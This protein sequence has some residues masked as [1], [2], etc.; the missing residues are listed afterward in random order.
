M[1]LLLSGR[2]EPRSQSH[3]APK[4]CTLHIAGFLMIAGT[5]IHSGDRLGPKPGDHFLRHDNRVANAP[6]FSV[7]K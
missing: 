2:Q 6:I 4:S 7:R 5:R 1:T 3:A